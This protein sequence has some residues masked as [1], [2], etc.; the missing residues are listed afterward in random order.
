[1]A[2]GALTGTTMT[3][4]QIFD[5]LTTTGVSKTEAQLVVA[6]WIL[7]NAGLLPRTFAYKTPFAAAEEDCVPQFARTFAHE[8][9]IDGENVVQAE[10]TTGEDGFNLRFHRIEGDLDALGRDV[11][12]AFVCIS[13]MRASLRSLLDELQAEVNLVHRAVA[14]GGRDGGGIIVEPGP[15]QPGPLVGGAYLG[16]T[17]YFDASVHVFETSSGRVMLPAVEGI[18]ITPFEN[19]RVQR[20]LAVGEF[21]TTPEVQQFFATGRPMPKSAFLERF[22]NEVLSNGEKLRDAIEIIPT[23]T[24]FPGGQSVVDGLAQREGAAIRTSG[25]EREAIEVAFGLEGATR[26]ADAPLDRLE[27]LPED[28]RTALVSAG[29]GTIGSF[30]D[31]NPN[32]LMRVLQSRGIDARAADV[33]GWVAAG[34]TLVNAR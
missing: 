24:E 26:V 21:V 5:K 13:S 34:K 20:T 17:K 14:R 3:A 32:E 27:I 11:A 12:Q 9:W 33:S 7:G 18:T 15:I 31:R 29:V 1:M 22:G 16:T 8:D 30:V 6:N 28:A 19:P 23:E 10:Q 2:I 25:L 4:E